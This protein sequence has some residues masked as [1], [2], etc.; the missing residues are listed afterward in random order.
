[1]TG[2]GRTE[3]DLLRTVCLHMSIVLSLFCLYIDLEQTI[4]SNHTPLSYEL[5]TMR[6]VFDPKWGSDFSYTL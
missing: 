3:V 4:N 6:T 5:P 1:M 2:A